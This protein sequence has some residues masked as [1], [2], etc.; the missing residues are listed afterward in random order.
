MTQE[1]SNGPQT[2]PV[3]SD[4]ETE[5]G[6]SPLTQSEITS[7][8]EPTVDVHLIT[9]SGYR[10]SL[11]FGADSAT[12]EVKGLLARV[13]KL[14]AY[15]VQEGWQA[16]T[17]PA[18][19]VESEPVEPAPT[20]STNLPTFCGYLA[21]WV[22]DDDGFPSYVIDPETGEQAKRVESD[23]DVWWTIKDENEKT[24][25]RHIV[26]ISKSEKKMLPEGA[27]WK[28]PRADTTEVEMPTPA[29]IE[30]VLAAGL[31]T[32]SDKWPQLSSELSLAFS[33]G[34]TEK[35]SEL[36]AWEIMALTAELEKSV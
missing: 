10:F 27:K 5:G 12:E 7:E 19:P 3:R 34:R 18:A 9:Q 31:R 11:T 2:E 22:I 21:S 8:S 17:D 28:P 4:N 25:Y 26:N 1:F 35:L 30:R 23:G 32:H 33:D 13:R 16:D 15:L 14:D 24:G 6:P 20:H 29:Q 36:T